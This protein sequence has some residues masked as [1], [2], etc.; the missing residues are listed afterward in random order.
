MLI[1]GA[2]RFGLAQVEEDPITALGVVA[3]VGGFALLALPHVQRLLSKRNGDRKESSERP[4]LPRNKV[5]T[6][7][8]AARSVP[9]GLLPR[10]SHEG[11]APPI[12]D[13]PVRVAL[14]DEAREVVAAE[15][16]E[17]GPRRHVPIDTAALAQT[18]RGHYS[19]GR[20]ILTDAENAPDRNAIYNTNQSFT[21]WGAAIEDT[22][23]G[24]GFHRMASFAIS[25]ER[26]DPSPLG[27]RLVPDLQAIFGREA[28]GPG[29][30]RRL[31]AQVKERLDRL[32]A[33]IEVLENQP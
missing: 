16:T 11:K 31:R 15:L 32:Q 1:Y 17:Q 29:G 9:S 28:V 10:E 6:K 5:E 27:L 24:Q 12:P 13:K 30:D 26:P 22:L 33:L 18:L 23:T 14:S 3:M 2:I 8:P 4:V 20:P 25:L 21:W 7:A 19:R